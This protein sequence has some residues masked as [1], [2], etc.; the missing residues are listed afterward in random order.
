[1]KWLPCVFRSPVDLSLLHHMKE[2]TSFVPWLH[3]SV[4]I[5]SAELKGNQHWP[6]TSETSLIRLNPVCQTSMLRANAFVG[7]AISTEVLLSSLLLHLTL[8]HLLWRSIKPRYR[9]HRHIPHLC[10]QA[11]CFTFG[12]SIVLKV[13]AQSEVVAKYFY[14]IYRSILYRKV[15]CSFLSTSRRPYST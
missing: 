4:Q 8:N 13:K 10:S 6:K 3:C 1:M 14:V 11:F 5:S 9:H 2:A 12:S 15:N 7:L